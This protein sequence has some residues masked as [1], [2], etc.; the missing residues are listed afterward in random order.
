MKWRQ[1]VMDLE[2]LHP[3]AVE[4][5]FARHGASS[6][7]LTDAGNQPVL[8][9]P[10]G[11]TPMWADM[12]ITGLFTANTDFVAL[13]ADLLSALGIADLPRHELTDL[14]DRDWE[15]EWLKDFS[16][17]QFGERLWI[18]PSNATVDTP[19]AAVVTLD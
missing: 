9:P 4:E 19:G 3:D 5:I 14:E 16:P 10:P 15:R 13:Q 8:E 7:T 17:M 12:R 6:I 11:E 2:T 1:F 18:C